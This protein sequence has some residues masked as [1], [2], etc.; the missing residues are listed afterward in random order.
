MF[1]TGVVHMFTCYRSTSVRVATKSSADDA[2]ESVGQP[3]KECSGN[4]HSMSKVLS[5][6]VINNIFNKTVF[7]KIRFKTFK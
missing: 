6:H 7:P 4:G 1:S 5:N 3:I 2:W